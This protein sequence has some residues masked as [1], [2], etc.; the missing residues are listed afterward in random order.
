MSV[1]N[2]A[3]S[4]LLL[5]QFVLGDAKSI[6]FLLRNKNVVK[7]TATIPHPYPNGLARKWIIGLN[8][9][10][11]DNQE[12]TWGITSL[13]TNELIGAISLLNYNK[14]NK[15]VEIGYWIG[16][17]FW[18]NGYCTEAGEKVLEFG[19]KK[20]GLNRIFGCHFPH[21]PASRKVLKKLGMKKEGIFRKH[22][23]RWGKFH[24]AEYHGILKEEWKKSKPKSV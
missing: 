23:K 2:L 15:H 10:I 3:T 9:R 5:R 4:R 20:L 19:F 21:N 1:P 7:T 6:Q 18:N 11:K 8:K 14:H 13:E 17:P 12:F 16:F 22:I 24:D